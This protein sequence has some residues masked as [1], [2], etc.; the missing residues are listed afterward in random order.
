M[1]SDIVHGGK[2]DILLSDINNFGILVRRVALALLEKLAELGDNLGTVEK[3]E[4]WVKTQK[5]TL[6]RQS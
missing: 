1:R 5:Y 3:L 6:P 4:T 2:R